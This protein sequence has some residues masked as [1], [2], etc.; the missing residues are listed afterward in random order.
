MCA[1]FYDPTAYIY[2]ENESKIGQINIVNI[3]LITTL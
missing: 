1:K 2:L 3:R